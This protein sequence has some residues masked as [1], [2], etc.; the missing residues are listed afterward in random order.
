MIALRSTYQ[1]GN[2][3]YRGSYTSMLKT[4]K[5]PDLVDDWAASQTHFWEHVY[6]GQRTFGC[7]MQGLSDTCPTVFVFDFDGDHVSIRDKPS[8]NFTDRERGLFEDCA[9][10]AEKYLWLFR[11]VI[12]SGMRIHVPIAFDVY[13]I[14]LHGADVPIFCFQKDAANRNILLPDIDFFWHGW[15]ER[16]YNEALWSEKQPIAFFA[17]SS[18]GGDLLS[19]DDV[20]YS[21]SQRLHWASS[22]INRPLVDIRICDAVQCDSI[23]TD[24]ELRDKPYFHPFIEWEDQLA[25]RYLISMDGNGA[26]CSRVV[27]TLK[28]KSVL[29]KVSSSKNLYYFEGLKPYENYIPVRS[30]SEVERAVTDMESGYIDHQKIILSANRFY[31]KYLS[32]SSVYRYT[33]KVLER[34]ARQVINRR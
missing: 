4:F 32:R 20:R 27:N 10:R 29:L 6:A 8:S 14:S 13:D 7:A 22:S 23:A 31:T 11:Q 25:F 16:T 26:T 2:K 18:T 9:L 24:R 21:R 17:G 19:L 34:Y 33:R 3:Q 15:Y 28:S 5:K 30:I 12:L 1:D